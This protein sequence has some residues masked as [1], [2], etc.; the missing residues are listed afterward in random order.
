MLN[1]SA[2]FCLVLKDD[3]IH[4]Y[5]E[6]TQCHVRSSA[7]NMQIMDSHSNPGSSA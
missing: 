6:K 3:Y 2:S 1:T 7:R 5:S 4:R